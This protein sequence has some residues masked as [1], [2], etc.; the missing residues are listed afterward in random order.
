MFKSLRGVMAL[1]GAMGVAAALLVAAQGYYFINR[2]DTSAVKVYVAKDVVA[3]ILPP[4]LYLIEARLVLS[5][6]LDGSLSAA[7]GKKRFD[8]LAGEYRTR[9]DYWNQN[10]PHGLEKSLLGAQHTAGQAFLAA[11][12]SQVIEPA[13]AG[14]LAQAQR[15]LPAVHALY[16]QHRE[17]VNA[18]V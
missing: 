13:A 16:L 9:V 18:T 5:M 7:D 12:R 3:D 10:P 4:P 8:E 17:G 14:Q 2:L 1:V 15:Q 11:A 6:V